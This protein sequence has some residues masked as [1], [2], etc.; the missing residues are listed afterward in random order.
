M[1]AMGDG[2]GDCDYDSDC[3]DGL[4]CFQRGGLTSV[5][6]CLGDG[7]P[8]WD[9]CIPVCSDALSGIQYSMDP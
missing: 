9:Y 8:D 3:K 5:P 2:T 1:A 7:T 6:G 4:R